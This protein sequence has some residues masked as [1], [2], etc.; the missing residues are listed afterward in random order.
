MSY[1]RDFFVLSIIVFF[2]SCST[3][4]SLSSTDSGN[5]SDEG[6]SDATE[7]EPA[8]GGISIGGTELSGDSIIELTDVPEEI[9]ISYTTPMDVDSLNSGVGLDCVSTIST[10]VSLS[11]TDSEDGI[12]N[13]DF[14]ITPNSNIPQY[15]NCS[16]NFAET[17]STLDDSSRLSSAEYN[18]MTPC[19]SRQNYLEEFSEEGTLENCWTII[20]S[21]D[22]VDYS[23]SEDKL[24]VDFD[25][26]AGTEP[27]LIVHSVDVS[28]ENL[29]VEM[30]VDEYE[31]V[32]KD[33]GGVIAILMTD[34]V[35][36]LDSSNFF[37]CELD[38]DPFDSGMEIG[39]V[40]SVSG[41]IGT[42]DLSDATTSNVLSET[43]EGNA[44]IFRVI[45]EDNQFTC[46]YRWEDEED[47]T[48]VLNHIE[49]VNVTAP[50]TYSLYTSRAEATTSGIHAEIDSFSVST[51]DE[52]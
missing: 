36:G 49:T 46:E 32:E 29:I 51:D 43:N 22:G 31:N 14:V 15:N 38:M 52:E 5:G 18:F 40:S 35:N 12:D 3:G 23:I 42:E 33:G 16:L 10:T 37:Y 7:E 44:L 26:T 45:K 19:S 48:V 47:Y 24:N 28:N 4:L 17:I 25:A 2:V 20:D 8:I 21:G 9:E 11:D 50:F 41:E 13:N 34:D 1:V 6:G 27:S 30:K 39:I